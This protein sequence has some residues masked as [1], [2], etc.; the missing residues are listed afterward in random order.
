MGLWD[1]FN[2]INPFALSNKE[3]AER[4]A[5]DA[6]KAA[7]QPQR[8]PEGPM[9]DYVPLSQ[10][11]VAVGS[12][13][14]AEQAAASRYAGLYGIPA[15]AAGAT[16]LEYN[17]S[18][19][20]QER[21]VGELVDNLY[22]WN[23]PVKVQQWQESLFN[24][25][26]YGNTKR[27]D[28]LWGVASDDATLKATVAVGMQAA[29]ASLDGRTTL[30]DVLES[31]SQAYMG[32]PGS[33][34][35]SSGA[36]TTTTTRLNQT[37]EMDAGYSLHQAMSRLLGRAPTAAEVDDFHGTLNTAERN[38][39]TVTTTTSD[40]AG[41]VSEESSGG[42]NAGGVD[43]LARQRINQENGV[44]RNK[45]GVMSYMQAFERAISGGFGG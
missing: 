12:T 19:G 43:E 32:S 7:Q 24:A 10:G 33:G 23:D 38:T 41:H 2:N 44:E 30:T 13:Q 9:D 25:G 5:E 16:F 31:S 42:M 45:Y 14:T 39:P 18:T 34:G 1:E 3:R 17:A 29:R 11:G 20:F 40:G 8:P 37:S 22:Q 6:R 35:S 28:I 21:R 26:Y 15:G 27:E 4:A 36:G